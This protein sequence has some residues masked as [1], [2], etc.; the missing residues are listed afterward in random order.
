MI[1]TVLF[2]NRLYAQITHIALVM[3]AGAASF[4]TAA[5]AI[6][7]LPLRTDQCLVITGDTR[8]R[9]HTR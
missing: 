4:Q 8:Y 9:N 5:Q 6:D 7:C 1:F 3:A 2:R